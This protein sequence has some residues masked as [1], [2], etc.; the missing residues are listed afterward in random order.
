MKKFIGIC[1]V[2]LLAI[3]AVN[4]EEMQ[5]TQKDLY[6]KQILANDYSYSPSGF[7]SAIKDGNTHYVDL[8]LKSGMDP[9]TTYLKVP[10]IYYAIKTKQPET[11]K[12]LLDAGVNPN[13]KVMKQTPLAA[14]IM[15]KNTKTVNYLIQH[16]ANVNTESLGIT[17]L[18]YALMKREPDVV[19]SLLNAGA[20]VDEEALKTALKLKDN[21]MKNMVLAKYKKQG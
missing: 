2:S 11:V 20:R 3:T 10:A 8:F 21:N 15:T 13:D 18:N 5:F 19:K 1:L 17:P 16:G 4:A 9:N 14:A 7:F 6:I 12:L